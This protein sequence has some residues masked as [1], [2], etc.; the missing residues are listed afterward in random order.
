MN[1]DT[2]RHH[3]RSRKVRCVRSTIIRLARIISFTIFLL[4][5]A[6]CTNREDSSLHLRGI[7]GSDH[8]YSSNSFFTEETVETAARENNL[9]F[10]LFGMDRDR[11]NEQIRHTIRAVIKRINK[12]GVLDFFE[13]PVFGSDFYPA[14]PSDTQS[15]LLRKRDE[16][17]VR[18]KPFHR[19]IG[20]N[21]LFNTVTVN[22][23]GSIID[24][25]DDYIG[26]LDRGYKSAVAVTAEI[27]GPEW[28]INNP[29]R[30]SVIADSDNPDDVKRAINSGKTYISFEPG[31][32]IDFLMYNGTPGDTVKP[33]YNTINYSIDVQSSEHKIGSIELLTNDGA[34]PMLRSKI[35][36]NR[37]TFSGDVHNP[38]DS[39]WYLVRVQLVNG[40]IAYTTPVWIERNR[41]IVMRE[42]T[43]KTLKP[44][45]NKR[46]I[47]YSFIV[48]NIS[49]GNLYDINCSVISDTGTEIDQFTFDI[50]KRES[51]KFTGDYFY[52]T[53]A[54]ETVTV[55][56]F[57]N[58]IEARTNIILDKKRTYKRVV[59]DAAHFNIFSD[60]FSSAIKALRE[61]GYRTDV[62]YRDDYED[63]YEDLK[64]YDLMIITTPEK[65]LELIDENFKFYY[66]IHLYVYFGGSIILAAYDSEQTQASTTFLNELLRVV[67]SPLRYRMDSKSNVF[68][69]Y[70]EENN[71]AGNPFM[72]VFDNFTD[73]GVVSLD[74]DAT[75][76]MRNPIE[77]YGHRKGTDYSISKLYWVKPLVM[78]N[79][80]TMVENRRVR[81]PETIPGAVVHKF[82]KGRVAVLSGINFSDYDIDALDNREWFMDMVNFLLE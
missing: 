13:I 61:Q 9:D 48:E 72:P 63:E 81:N 50:K 77:I 18:I 62:V 14:N 56:C 76:Y 80:S 66:A 34:R 41:S 40:S 36:K 29:V 21:I 43:Q 79:S 52:D 49:P 12:K 19:E 75:I 16:D 10:W 2:H 28:R 15:L 23:D 35:E 5:T 55:R 24:H 78:L 42:V 17:G 59:F 51:R 46:V 30:M 68:P 39:A 53:S 74:G 6:G 33:L 57:T 31:V 71:H 45:K 54:D 8:F 60:N 1:I 69:L 64:Q 20:A 70:D 11:S 4:F 73:N 67:Y 37:A 3:A 25:F 44:V 38:N 26:L 65:V 7:A 82:G 47:E 27:L 58:D 32:T 22:Y